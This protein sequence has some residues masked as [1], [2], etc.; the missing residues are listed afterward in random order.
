MLRRPQEE[1]AGGC[2]L[3]PA[4]PSERTV[5]CKSAH[6]MFAHEIQGECHTRLA[7]RGNGMP[8]AEAPITSGDF[9]ELCAAVESAHP[10]PEP[11]QPGLCGKWWW[12][13]SP[14]MVFISLGFLFFFIFTYFACR[15]YSIYLGHGGRSIWGHLATLGK[16]KTKIRV[17][18]DET[19]WQR[20]GGSKYSSFL[21]QFVWRIS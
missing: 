8:G 6:V 11:R 16:F 13:F 21:L 12:W 9:R 1:V 20:L 4:L 15:R 7:G 14:G 17:Q 18:A 19:D 2:F 3:C 10:A 5:C